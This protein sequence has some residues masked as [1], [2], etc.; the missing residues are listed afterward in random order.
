MRNASNSIEETSSGSHAL[1]MTAREIPGK[2]EKVCANG[3][4]YTK[5]GL[6]S[7]KRDVNG[8]KLCDGL[9]DL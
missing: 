3:A 5:N 9:K 2:A 4:T 7:H 6:K 1:Y 8:T